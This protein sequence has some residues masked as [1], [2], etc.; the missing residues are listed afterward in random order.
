MRGGQAHCGVTVLI[1]RVNISP[2]L[3]QDLHC[4]DMSFFTSCLEWGSLVD[5]VVSDIHI[6]A[7][8]DQQFGEVGPT[9][10]GCIME[11]RNPCV[12]S[13]VGISTVFEQY[14]GQLFAM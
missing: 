6:G 14:L 9:L 1:L 5:I 7:A 4:I 13:D 12:P 11:G 10:H 2:F 8:L 3:E